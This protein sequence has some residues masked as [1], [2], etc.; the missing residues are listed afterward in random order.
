MKK[1]FGNNS[2]KR[3]EILGAMFD[4]LSTAIRR[5]GELNPSQ[6]PRMADFARWAIAASGNEDQFLTDYAEN[7]ERQNSEALNGSVVATVLLD[8]LSTKSEWTGQAQE[9]YAELLEKANGLKIPT[10]SFPGSAA[11]LGRR[12]R[13]I[14]PNL[15]ALGWKIDFGDKRRPR[16]T[17]I[18]R[19]L[20]E[21]TVGAD[22]ADVQADSKD[23]TDSIFR[24]SS[25]R[26]GDDPW[27]KDLKDDLFD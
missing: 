4:R 14:R 10:K 15:T 16:I 25:G 11:A 22:G 18:T 19:N 13:E 5:Y 2:T 24:T 8:Y 26:V 1:A 21:N 17:T 9:L 3:P 27:D 20:T 7:V 6:L 12:L 23:A